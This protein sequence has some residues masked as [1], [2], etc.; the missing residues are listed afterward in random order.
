MEGVGWP[1]LKRFREYLVKT[2]GGILT[3]GKHRGKFYDTVLGADPDYCE[4]AI[5]PRARP[6]SFLS[7]LLGASSR[8]RRGHLRP[9][10]GMSPTHH[11]ASGVRSLGADVQCGT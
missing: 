11:V 9:L 2:H 5:Q 3:I 10:R 1:S 7:I 4:W 8:A 6:P